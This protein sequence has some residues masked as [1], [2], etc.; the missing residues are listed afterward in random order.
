MGG[1]SKFVPPAQGRVF[2]PA[3][4]YVLCFRITYFACVACFERIALSLLYKN[5]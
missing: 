3:G 4:G 5:L 2:T 1:T